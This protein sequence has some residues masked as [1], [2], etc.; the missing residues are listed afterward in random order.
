L[1]A[2]ISRTVFITGCSTGIGRAV[3]V[4]C[5][6]AGH[7]VI[8]TT[9]KLEMLTELADLALRE[10][11]QLKTTACDVTDENSMLRA[12]E[13]ARKSFGDIH[14]LVNN[15]GYGAMGPIEAVPLAEARRQLEVN[16]FGAMRLVQL[17]APDM[18]RA[19]WGRIIN[20]TSV[21]GR[22]VQ[23]LSGWY[24]ASKFAMEALNDTLRLELEPFNIHTVSILPGPVRTAFTSNM[25][26][27]TLPPDM[28]DFYRRLI[29]Y[30]MTLQGDRPFEVLPEA[31]AR[32]ILRAIRAHRPRPHYLI[33]MPAHIAIRVR[34]F[35]TAR[36]WDKFVKLYFGV[37][38]A[39]AAGAGRA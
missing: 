35:F 16:T 34:P 12:V 32:L 27:P 9:P 2:L 14:V 38:K 19:G 30:R 1:S 39:N 8:A 6:R 36:M 13:F 22:A 20:V 4:L 24:C 28:P 15:A 17:I 11:L 5:A 26:I 31:V 29:A 10:S 18:R 21:L 3:A 37:D 7:R 23:P 25:T 33:T